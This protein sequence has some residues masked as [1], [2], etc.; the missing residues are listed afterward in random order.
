MKEEIFTIIRKVNITKKKTGKSKRSLTKISVRDRDQG[1]ENN[2]VRVHNREK[3]NS[4]INILIK[5]VIEATIN[6]NINIDY[7]NKY[8]S[9]FHS[10]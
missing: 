1:L 6:N 8:I 9:I 10:M 2:I 5:I 7:P 3:I 4:K